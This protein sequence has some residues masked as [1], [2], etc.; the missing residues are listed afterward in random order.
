MERPREV[1]EEQGGTTG[2][3]SDSACRHK[4][5]QEQGCESPYLCYFVEFLVIL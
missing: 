3:S 5:V 2:E 1:Q 4:Q